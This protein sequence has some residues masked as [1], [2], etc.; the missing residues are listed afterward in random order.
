LWGT[1]QDRLVTELRLLRATTLF[2]ANVALSSFVRRYNERFAVPPAEAASAYRPLPA[3]LRL[4]QL[5]CFKYERMVAADNTVQLGPHRIHLLPDRH[6][7]SYTRAK[8]ELQVRMDGAIAV[9]YQG[10]LVTSEP[11]PLETPV[12][13]IQGARV[14]YRLPAPPPPVRPLPLALAH[15]RMHPRSLE[16][17]II[18]TPGPAPVPGDNHPW[19]KAIRRDVD[20][21][22]RLRDQNDNRAADRITDRL[23]GQNH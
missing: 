8:V 4:E 1:F 6:R 20:H 13:R 18:R 7:V 2:E 10:R 22:I 9:Y 16:D 23:N 12:L 5:F 3:D 17:G 19:R 14:T 11:A 15:R 21:A